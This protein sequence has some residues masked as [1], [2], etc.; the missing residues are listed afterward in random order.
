MLA[1]SWIGHVLEFKEIL[2]IHESSVGILIGVAIGGIAFAIGSSGGFSGLEDEFFFNII[3]PP[4]IF[5]AAYSMKKKNFFSNIGTVFTFG[6]IATL[7][8]FTTIALIVYY[9]SEQ[10]IFVDSKSKKP[11]YITWDEAL[12]IAAVF[13]P[14]DSVSAL[15][16]L[17]PIE[18]PSLHS[19]LAGEGNFF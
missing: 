12:Q 8:T 17:D 9:A 7:L 18:F 5:A 10:G 15:S 4:I 11:Y 19:V 3:L 14:T 2:L 13:S 6:V 16:I 1:L